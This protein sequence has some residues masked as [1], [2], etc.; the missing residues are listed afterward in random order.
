MKVKRLRVRN[1]TSLIDVEIGDLPNFVVLIGKNS[2]GKSNLI[3]ALALLFMEFGTEVD[4]DMGSL[5]NYLHLF[6]GHASQGSQPPE[7]EATLAL[8]FQ[9]W[10]VLL[11]D[12]SAFFDRFSDLELHVTKRLVPSDNNLTWQTYGVFIGPI[13]LV[14]EGQI[15]PVGAEYVETSDILSRLAPLMASSFQIIYTTERPHSWTNR[16]TE[17]PTIIGDEQI[18]EMWTLSQSRGNNRRPW[19]EAGRKFS[20]IAPN[21]QR[22]SGVSSSIQLE[23]NDLSVPIGMT[24]E[25]SQATLSLVDKVERGSNILAIEE[26]ETHLHPELVKKMAKLLVQATEEGKQLFVCTHSPFMVEHSPLDSFFVVTKQKDNTQVS[27][28]HD[29]GGLRNLLLDIGLRPSDVLFSDAILLVEGL[30]DEIFFERL[31]NKIDVA[32]AD[33]RVKIVR[34][35]GYPRGRRKIEFWAEVGQDAGLPLY[36]I[37]DKNASD[38]A[39][40]AIES[41]QI[42]PEHCLI[43]DKGDIEDHYPWSVLSEVLSTRFN[44]QTEESILPGERVKRLSNLLSQKAGGKNAWKPM[45]AEEVVKSMTREQAESDLGEVVSFLRRIHHEVG[46]E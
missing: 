25:G 32:L 46:G 24:G 26:P 1:F 40:H 38:E 8:T 43:L 41:G 42:R 21:Y 13:G 16:F 33:R 45:V 29:I 28:M 9:E 18:A 11:G 31:S 14:I 23:E 27:R 7:I 37:L 3:D 35:N 20:S 12:P 39:E 22:P 19:L 10:S 15:D 2:S 34:A 4:Q 36:L 30:S 6:P 17:R 5:D 44:I